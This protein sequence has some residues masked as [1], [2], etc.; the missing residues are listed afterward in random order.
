MRMLFDC[1]SFYVRPLF[2]GAVVAGPLL[3]QEQDQ[4]PPA[5]LATP[6]AS[7]AAAPVHGQIVCVNQLGY[8]SG[9]PKRFTVP[10]AIDAEEPVSFSVVRVRDGETVFS[11]QIEQGLGDF[12][13]FRPEGESE[14][15]VVE[16][17]GGDA[18][19]SRSFPFR[20]G[21]RALEELTV[22]PAIDFMIDCRSVVGTH[23][24]AYG[25]LPWRKG[26]R[27]SYE[28]P[29]LALLYMA[30]PEELEGLSSQ[31]DWEADK[32]V[33]TDPDFRLRRT[34][35]DH[36][37]VRDTC[38]YF[39]HNQPPAPGA[40]DIAKLL[41]WGAG[42][43]MERP[44]YNYGKVAGQGIPRRCT[45]QLAYFL[46]VY[47][48]LREWI[49]PAF[50]Q[51]CCEFTFANWEAGG[52]LDVFELWSM[53]DSVEPGTGQIG[54]G[55]SILANLLLHEVAKREGRNDSAIYLRAAVAQ[56][57]WIVANVDFSDPRT[58]KRHRASEHKTITGLVWLLQNYPEDAPKGLAEKI[59]AW[60][61][62]AISRSENM[63]DFRRYDLESNWSIPKYN[64]PG[65]LAGFPACA[66]AA[67]WVI[68][69][70][71]KRERLRE[72]AVAAWDALFGRNPLN[73]ASP[74]RPDL[75]WTGI[76]RGWPV[77]YFDPGGRFDLVRGTLSSCAPTPTYP[78]DPAGS[79][80][81]ADEDPMNNSALN[82][83]LAYIAWDKQ[84]R[85]AIP[86]IKSIKDSK[87]EDR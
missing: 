1:L 86:T 69:D 52:A 39:T 54:T 28:L 59:E 19:P 43:I 81:E 76:E 79:L 34:I 9:L 78:F 68:E 35:R 5:E 58:T 37:V 3:G 15:Y 25:G 2:L 70:E 67:S 24:S 84:R 33:V 12:S 75:G 30:M 32:R 60:A 63:W 40:P 53:T 17:D 44:H 77:S 18:G 66:L 36:W 55:H 22:K 57:A 11:G 21:P 73:A 38:E 74:Y 64:E 47:P 51:K 48:R 7:E 31:I 27:W 26:T 20:V 56:A 50:Y 83:G 85:A 29:S 42:F 14:E 10:T 62:V 49:D 87:T 4:A 6:S 82:V 16:V 65:N 45:E 8:D 23:P 46:A 71:A 41:H 80:R 61:D 72:I 13:D